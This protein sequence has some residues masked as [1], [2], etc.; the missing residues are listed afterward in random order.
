M[1]IIIIII[2]IV[3]MSGLSPFENL[4][5]YLPHEQLKR[6]GLCLWNQTVTTAIA[7]ENAMTTPKGFHGAKTLA[8]NLPVLVKSNPFIITIIS[9]KAFG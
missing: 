4:I 1:I 6:E 8:E 2:I 9:A 5:E 7:V 3:I